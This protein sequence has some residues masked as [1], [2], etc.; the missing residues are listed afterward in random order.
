[1]G[2]AIDVP[3]MIKKSDQS[4]ELKSQPAP[5]VGA[6]PY[7]D[8]TTALQDRPGSRWLFEVCAHEQR[9]IALTAERRVA[10]LSSSMWG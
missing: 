6:V 2:V 8:S 10:S 7:L 1:M 5:I 4:V 9:E 3:A